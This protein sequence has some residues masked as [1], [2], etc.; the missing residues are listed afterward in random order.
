MSAANV[1]TWKSRSPNRLPPKLYLPAR[2]QVGVSARS[3]TFVAALAIHQALHLGWVSVSLHVDCGDRI[4]DGIQ[5]VRTQFKICAAEVFFET[6]QLG[7]SWD[8]ND[9]RFLCQK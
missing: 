1:V 3:L 6:M 5:I 4:M 9:P 7:R 8:R 2:R